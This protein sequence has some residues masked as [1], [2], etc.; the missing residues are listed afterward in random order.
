MN[1]L[2]INMKRNKTKKF[3]ITI[4]IKKHSKRKIKKKS[5]N[6]L[7]EETRKEQEQPKEKMNIEKELIDR[8]KE[9]K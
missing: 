8:K 6:E 1:S 5:Q 4:R 7:I 3:T 9:E 2:F